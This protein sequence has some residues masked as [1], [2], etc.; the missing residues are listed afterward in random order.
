MLNTCNTISE[1][2]CL[3]ATV[4]KPNIYGVTNQNG[5]D[6]LNIVENQSIT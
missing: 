2:G 5:A 3:N 1:I 6:N 4:L